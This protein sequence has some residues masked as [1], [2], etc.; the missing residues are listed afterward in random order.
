MQRNL[1]SKWWIIASLIIYNA[2]RLETRVEKESE[3]GGYGDLR[4]EASRRL[5]AILGKEGAIS[6][7]QN[8][9][10]FEHHVYNYGLL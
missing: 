5:Q 7:P 10:V 1:N 4:G 6:G 8:L 3:R 9:K 2:I